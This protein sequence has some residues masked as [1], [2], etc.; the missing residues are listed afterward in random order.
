MI[1]FEAF[2]VAQVLRGHLALALQSLELH[3][4][5]IERI[6]RLVLR[7]LYPSE[8]DRHVRTEQPS[9]TGRSLPGLILNLSRAVAL[10]ELPQVRLV[11]PLKHRLLDFQLCPV[12]SD[13]RPRLFGGLLGLSLHAGE[14]ASHSLVFL[15]EKVLQLVLFGDLR[16]AIVPSLPE[17]L[18]DVQEH[19]W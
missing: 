1:N 5:R 8:H 12:V 2:D 19:L 4:R 3:V 10:A 11:L 15:L 17:I 14:V 13:A 18:I 7:L 6:N 9:L 16:D